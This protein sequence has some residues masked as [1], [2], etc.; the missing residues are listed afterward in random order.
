MTTII[1]SDKFIKTYTNKNGSIFKAAT[2]LACN[3]IN[4][5]QYGIIYDDFNPDMK[6]VNEWKRENKDMKIFHVSTRGKTLNMDSK[7]AFHKKMNT[8]KFT[9]ESYL[10]KSNVTDKNGIYFVKK[11]GS[12][13][14]RG[15]NVYTYN[16]LEG[17]DISNSVVQKSMSEPDLHNKKRYKIR[18]LVFLHNKS[19]YIHKE[20]W[21]SLSDVNYD[22]NSTMHSKHVIFQKAGTEFILSKNLLQF[23]TI[24]K[25]MLNGVTDFAKLYHDEIQNINENE[26]VILGFD[27]VVDK[28]K[29]VQIIEIN[30]R[31]NY[32]H[33]KNVRESCDIGGIKDLLLLLINQSTEGT[34]LIKICE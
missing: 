13:G 7:I 30:H 18:Q 21:T 10:K 29:N 23:T 28:E 3:S 34:Q 20:S 5:G 9:P 16:Q 6:K 14:S 27:F 15:V 12:T 17:V 22:S 2:N 11:D 25:N 19:C 8:S 31:S 26:F 4:N 32:S 1:A 24:Y 33:P